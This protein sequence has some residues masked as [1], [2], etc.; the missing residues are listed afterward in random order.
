MSSYLSFYI[1]KKDT[2]TY[3]P[4]YSVSRSNKFY[5]IFYEEFGCHLDNNHCCNPL[6]SADLNKLFH[7]AESEM[8]KYNAHIERSIQQ[9]ADIAA[10]NN[11]IEEKLEAI[12]DID[13]YI[14]YC[15]EEQNFLAYIHNV[16]SFLICVNEEQYDCEH[17][18]IYAGI[19]GYR[20]DGKEEK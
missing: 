13:S 5:E 4:L 10:W 6:S 12:A 17:P 3:T 9:K 15:K 14:E 2:D 8:A 16:C 18:V 11:S 1:R 7:L 19:D 20:P